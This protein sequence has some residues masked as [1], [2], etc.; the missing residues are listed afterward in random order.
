MPMPLFHLGFP[1]SCKMGRIKNPNFTL[2][3]LIYAC[4]MGKITKSKFQIKRDNVFHK[5]SSNHSPF[6]LNPEEAAKMAPFTS[7]GL[8][9]WLLVLIMSHKLHKS[10]NLMGREYSLKYY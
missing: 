7:D 2:K 3:R 10:L 5:P 8:V 6:Y 4:K 1:K 9:G